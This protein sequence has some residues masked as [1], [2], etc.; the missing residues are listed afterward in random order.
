MNYSIDKWDSIV[1][2]YNK[3][4]PII[5]FKADTR[6][7]EASRK[8]ANF[9]QVKIADTGSVYDNFNYIF[10]TVDKSP[11]EGHYT[12]VLQTDFKN[13]PQKLG[14]FVINTAEYAPVTLSIGEDSTPTPTDYSEQNQQAY[15]KAMNVV[16]VIAAVTILGSA[17]AATTL[18]GAAPHAAASG[19]TGTT[20]ST[21]KGVGLH[22]SLGLGDKVSSQPNN[23]VIYD[24]TVNITTSF[25]ILMVIASIM[26]V[27]FGVK[28]D[29]SFGV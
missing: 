11:V 22:S 3:L 4:S 26:S 13:I 27:L 2:K 28:P 9:I 5:Y 6:F 20:K 18:Q 10:A 1:N 15:N 7:V 21:I 29:L 25:V 8:N 16:K 19:A 12:M 17:F 24:K 14:K 23:S